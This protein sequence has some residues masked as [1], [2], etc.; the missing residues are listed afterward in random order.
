MKY[1]EIM[2]WFAIA[3]GVVVT[4]ADIIISTYKTKKKK[5]KPV[6]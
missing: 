2:F 1:L 4:F 3:I 6:D 5:D